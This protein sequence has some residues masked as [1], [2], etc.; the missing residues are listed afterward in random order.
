MPIL[1]LI[2]SVFLSASYNIFGEIFNRRNKGKTDASAFYT[3]LLMLSVCMGWGILYAFDFSFEINVLWYSALFAACYILTNVGMINALKYGS[4]TLTTLLI[5]LSLLVTTIWG[6]IFWGAKVTLPVIVGLVFVVI[7]I[8]LCLYTKEKEEKTFSLKWL[9]FVMLAFFGNAGCTIV[10]R[11]QQVK[12]NGQHGNMLM[13]FATFFS[14]LFCL[15][16]Y[17]KSDKKDSKEMLKDSWWAPVC[18]GV[19]NVALNI[20]VMLMAL[21]TLS[22]SLIYPVIGVGGLAVVTV[23]SLL[24]FKE[25]MR[26]WQWIGIVI[27]MFAVLLLSI[28]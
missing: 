3:F 12:F 28:S 10:Q 20:L 9:F 17:L 4:V 7:A 13:L 15:F 19:S 16:M 6:F 14:A 24:V 25:K 11:T 23:F 26:W 1:Y 27:G 5:S 22:P 18:A 2:S 8:Y 21:T